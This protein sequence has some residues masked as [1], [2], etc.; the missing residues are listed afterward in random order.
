MSLAATGITSETY[1]PS[2][3]TLRSTHPS[4]DRLTSLQRFAQAYVA[5]WAG[6]DATAVSGLYALDATLTDELLDLSVTG[7]DA[8]GALARAAADRGGLPGAT[9]VGLPEL[10]GPAVFATGNPDPGD[11]LDTVVLL[12]SPAGDCPSHVAIVLRLDADGRIAGEAR[13]HGA[14][15]VGGCSVPRLP[16]TPWWEGLAIPPGVSVAHSGTLMVDDRTIEVRNSSPALDELLSWGLGRFTEAGLLPP[17]VES[18]T[19]V[20]R[21][22][23]A[24]ARIN[25]LAAG[26]QVSLCFGTSD[27]CTDDGCTGWRA[28]AKKAV[29]HELS[30]VWM[31]QNVTPETQSTFLQTSA[32]PT[33]ESADLPWGNRGV[34]LAAE[35]MSGALMDEPVTLNVKLGRRYTCAELATLY[36]AL[37]GQPPTNPPCTG[38]E[39]PPDSP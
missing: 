1:A 28:W 39:L 38:D 17:A 5:A 25:G 11:P 35:T 37:V 36:T 14:T 12:L 19:F 2:L 26:G 3:V 20:D 6:Q 7:P 15:D 33:W 16:T 22:A 27:A 30:H 8:V 21:K 29:L 9:L 34:E 13:H 32:L 18:V 10:G 24:C 4:D 31:T 23:P